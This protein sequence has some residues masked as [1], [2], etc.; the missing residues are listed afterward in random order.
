[1][2]FISLNAATIL[3]IAIF[4][5]TVLVQAQTSKPIEE[6]SYQ[7]IVDYVSKLPSSVGMDVTAPLTKRLYEIIYFDNHVPLAH[8]KNAKKILDTLKKEVEKT[9]KKQNLKALRAYQKAYKFQE[10]LIP[11]NGYGSLAWLLKEKNIS[12]KET[13]PF[14]MKP[15]YAHLLKNLLFMMGDRLKKNKT[16]PS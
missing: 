5:P 4:A 3:V 8:R 15:K 9:L 1:M 16:V 11:I 13:I 12:D 14:V 10:K 7:K 6:M 2:R